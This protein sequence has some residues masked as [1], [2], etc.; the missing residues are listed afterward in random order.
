MSEMTCIEQSATQKG[1]DVMRR[2]YLAHDRVNWSVESERLSDDVIQNGKVF[3]I[4]VGHVTER[5]VW[6]AKLFLLFLVEFLP[7]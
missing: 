5:A 4:F 1:A 6:V 3:E 7:T 2:A